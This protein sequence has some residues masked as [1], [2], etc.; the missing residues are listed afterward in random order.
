MKSFK[1]NHL[2]GAFYPVII[3]QWNEV[4]LNPRL[5]DC[6]KPATLE[7]HSK[8]TKAGIRVWVDSRETQGY[9]TSFGHCEP[10]VQKSPWFHH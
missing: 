2:F 5:P 8:L 9:S 1:V 6:T 4:A 10:L 3:G 7:C